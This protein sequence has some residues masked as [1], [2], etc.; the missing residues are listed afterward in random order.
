MVQCIFGAKFTMV[1]TVVSRLV[2]NQGEATGAGTYVYDQDPVTKE[3]KM[4]FVAATD[5]DLVPGSL[6]DTAEYDIP[7]YARGYTDLG[8]RSSANKEFYLK[9]DYTPFEAIEFTF[10]AKYTMVSRQSFIKNIRRHVDATDA[11]WT[12]EETGEPTVFQ[13]QGVTPVF[14]GFGKHV[15]NTTVL[16]RSEIQ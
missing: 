1:A 4:K 5:P 10:P 12:E 14:D 13:V 2:V 15:A 11:F 8:Y 3:I 16:L 7:C 6:M 9:G